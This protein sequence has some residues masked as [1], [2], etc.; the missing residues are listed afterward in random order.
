MRQFL[1]F[2]LA[3]HGT[4]HKIY[5]TYSDD[6]TVHRGCRILQ[7]VRGPFMPPWLLLHITMY[8]IVA[9]YRASR[10]AR[11]GD[12]LHCY[13]NCWTTCRSDAEIL[14]CLINQLMYCSALFYPT[15]LSVRP[16]PVLS[17]PFLSCPALYLSSV[18]VHSIPL[19]TIRFCAA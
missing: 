2:L 10:I 3:L 11:P 1:P 5:L 8:T 19:F 17:C 13:C 14:Q 7:G 6:I 16:C 4:V 18:V 12:L 9:V 15:L